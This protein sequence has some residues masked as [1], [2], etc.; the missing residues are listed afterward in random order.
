MLGFALGGHLIHLH[1]ITF[2]VTRYS[3][4]YGELA[5]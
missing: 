1:G 4:E 5:E 3:V 2:M